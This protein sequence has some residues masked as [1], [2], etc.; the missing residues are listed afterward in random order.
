[1]IVHL[2]FIWCNITPVRKKQAI[3]EEIIY[4]INK[5]FNYHNMEL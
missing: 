3:I 2:Y 5:W 4:I 1:M